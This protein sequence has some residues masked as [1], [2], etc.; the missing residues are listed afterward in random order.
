MKII[1][2]K[3]GRY[4][5][6]YWSCYQHIE[7]CEDGKIISSHLLDNIDIINS[8]DFFHESSIANIVKKCE[9]FIS[10][11]SICHK[12]CDGELALEILKIIKESQ[13]E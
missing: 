7:I 11:V 4:T 9:E 8:D 10:K 12:P 3:P 1:D 5:H 13:C 6:K 2:L